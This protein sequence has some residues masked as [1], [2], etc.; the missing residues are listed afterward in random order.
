[1]LITI[2]VGHRLR[3]DIRADRDLLARVEALEAEADKLGEEVRQLESGMGEY[4]LKDD[5]PEIE[6][7]EEYIADTTKL[8]Q[9]VSDL[10]FWKA[11]RNHSHKEPE[12]SRGRGDGPVD[13][14]LLA[15][16]GEQ[17]DPDA[18]H[19]RVEVDRGAD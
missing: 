2:Q 3:I 7:L 11:D 9:E 19:L 16:V 17:H 5:V 12:P 6:L 15:A 10:N 4:L 18:D 1:M 14:Q 13:D 8:Q